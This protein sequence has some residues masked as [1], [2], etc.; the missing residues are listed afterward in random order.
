[1]EEVAR[2]CDQRDQLYVLHGGVM[3]AS[4]SP[5]E[6]FRDSAYLAALGLE[7]PEATQVCQKLRAGGLPAPLDALTVEEVGDALVALLRE[8]A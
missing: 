7:P 3:A 4:G 5:R 1:M 6:V 8:S 2:L